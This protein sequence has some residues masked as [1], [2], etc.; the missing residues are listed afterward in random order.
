MNE[1]NLTQLLNH[2]VTI[3]TKYRAR[4]KGENYFLLHPTI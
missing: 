4:I 3:V 2:P 1:L